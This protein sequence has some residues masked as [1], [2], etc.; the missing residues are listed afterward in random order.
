MIEFAV[1][2][3][4]VRLKQ[5]G[6]EV[7]VL[8]SQPGPDGGDDWRG[9]VVRNARKVADLATE[10]SPLVGYVLLGLYGDGATSVGY[11]YDTTAKGAIPRALLPSF[12]AEVVRRDLIA[13]EGAR[14]VFHEMFEWQGG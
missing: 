7:R 5:G 13:N 14:D 1:R 4:K 8:R 11:R 2:L 6:A 9:A 12:I 10:D 3:R